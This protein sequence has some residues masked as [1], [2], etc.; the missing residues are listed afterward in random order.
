MARIDR[1]GSSAGKT[2][3]KT[4]PATTRLPDWFVEEVTVDYRVD[5]R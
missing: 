2:S 4:N 3:A 5:T 1:R